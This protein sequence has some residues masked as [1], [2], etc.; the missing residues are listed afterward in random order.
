MAA[1]GR[2]APPKVPLP[3]D[4]GRVKD[5]GQPGETGE[6]SYSPGNR[7]HSYDTRERPGRAG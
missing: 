6:A 2:D 7:A 4:R 3:S 1:A 5:R